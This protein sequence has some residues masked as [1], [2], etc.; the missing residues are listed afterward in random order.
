[1]APQLTITPGRF[2][3]HELNTQEPDKSCAFYAEL[4][5]WTFEKTAQPGYLYIKAGNVQVGGVLKAPMPNIPPHWLPYVSVEDVDASQRLAIDAGCSLVAGPM[6]VAAGRLVIVH[7]PQGALFTLW[8]DAHG[9][10]P[11]DVKP[12]TGT[13]C[14]DRLVTPDPDA[15]FPV[16]A[17]IF[18]WTRKATSAASDVSMLMRGERIAGSLHKAPPGVPAHWLSYVQVDDIA[19]A[20]E[21]AKK[22]GGTVLVERIEIP[23]AGALTVLADS[24]GAVFAA[25]ENARS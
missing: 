15:A 22:L 8:R 18:G 25:F 1:M 4:F 10:G 16:Y 23:N 13:F 12:V 24:L 19:S 5:G 21:R 2:V 11:E 9:D 20:R 6:D 7:D 14:W 17:K 3:W